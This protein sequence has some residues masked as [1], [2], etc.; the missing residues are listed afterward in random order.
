[1]IMHVW[2]NSHALIAYHQLTILKNVHKKLFAL[3][4]ISLDIWLMIV[5]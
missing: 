1:M 2:I 4:V 3:D 5:N